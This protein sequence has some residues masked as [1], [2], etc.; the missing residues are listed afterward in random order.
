VMVRKIILGTLGIAA[1]LVGIVLLVLPGPG[2]LL[3][4]LGLVLLSL[5]FEWARRIVDSFRNWAR[6][7]R[8]RSTNSEE[9]QQ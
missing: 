1:I 8:I 7:R 6:R 5:E 9:H 2:L 3:I 4:G